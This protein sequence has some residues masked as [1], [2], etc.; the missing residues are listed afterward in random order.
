[1]NRLPKHIETRSRLPQADIDYVLN[2]LK[3][4]S[5]MRIEG[6]KIVMKMAFY[7]YKIEKDGKTLYVHVGSVFGKVLIHISEEPFELSANEMKSKKEFY[8]KEYKKAKERCEN[9]RAEAADQREAYKEQK[10]EIKKLLIGNGVKIK[11]GSPLS[12]L[13]RLDNLPLTSEKNARI[14]AFKQWH[15]EQQQDG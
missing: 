2:H 12:T 15:R 4:Q 13:L 14:E 6:N 3:D 8:E 11:K 9:C 7:D 1:M 10:K 5:Y